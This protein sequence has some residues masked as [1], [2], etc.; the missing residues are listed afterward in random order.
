[1][2]KT[3]FFWP[4]KNPVLSIP[5]ALALG[6][7]IG[8]QADTTFL[9]SSILIFTF[10]MIYPTMIGVK[11]R[12]AFDLSHAKVVG[13]SLLIN[14]LLIPL[15]AWGLGKVFL[16]NDPTMMAGLAIAGLLPTSGM[17]ISWTMMFKGNVPAAVKMTALSLI[18]GS[19]LAPFYLLLMVG[20][21]V[22]VDIMKT[23]TTIAIIVFLPMILGHFT[24]QQLLR[25]YG[26]EH[27]QKVLKPYMPAFS[28][29]AM[30][31]VIFSSISMK[32]KTVIAQPHLIGGILVA[33]VIFYLANFTVST[34]M[35]RLFFAKPDGIALIYGTVMRNL[36]IALGLAITAFGPQA[37]LVVTLA[38]ILQVQAAAWYGKLAEQYHF[39]G[40]PQEVTAKQ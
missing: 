35:A 40:K 17:T 32:A 8:L 33:L 36:S 2:G 31:A 7:L 21:Y 18:V 26:Q 10:L 6:F 34:V 22:P 20:K 13:I 4:S 37:G 24:F 11:L 39:F 29:W 15:L 16:S 38:F 1:M 12:E 28:F 25:R 23:F 30:L 14:F 27:F 19:L 3:V 5:L 9:S